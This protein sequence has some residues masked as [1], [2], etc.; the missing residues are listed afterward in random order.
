MSKLAY[1]SSLLAFCCCSAQS[2]QIALADKT[3]QTAIVEEV[4]ALRA[5]GCTCGDQYY[6]K[7]NPL[8]W[9]DQ[10]EA[11]AELHTR[12]MEQNGFFDH[13]GSDGSSAGDRMRRVGYSW[14][15]YGENIGWGYTDE[16]DVVLGWKNSP[17]H[18]R[19]MMDPSFKE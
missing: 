18:C 5:Q 9:N 12:D 1:L 10:L 6:G 11:A 7:T 19:L 13:R 2:E 17:G 8:V 15:A 16:A 14:T 3:I 4:N